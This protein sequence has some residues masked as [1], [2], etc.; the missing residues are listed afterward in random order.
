MRDRDTRNL[1]NVEIAYFGNKEFIYQLWQE[2][3]RFYADVFAETEVGREIEDRNHIEI[4][5]KI[6]PK[7]GNNDHYMWT[8]T[9]KD[10]EESLLSIIGYEEGYQPDLVEPE[11]FNELAELDKILESAYNDESVRDV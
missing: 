2:E 6:N 11:S 7:P 1:E 8:P 3:N 9:A 10:S 5:G 4:I